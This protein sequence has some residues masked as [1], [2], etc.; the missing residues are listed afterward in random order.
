[1][2]RRTDFG[3]GHDENNIAKNQIGKR[4]ACVTSQGNIT[5]KSICANGIYF[6]LIVLA[7]VLVLD[8]LK[9]EDENEDDDEQDQDKD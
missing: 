4:T 8:I 7:L 2:N 9:I 5:A 3:Y 1:M 6:V